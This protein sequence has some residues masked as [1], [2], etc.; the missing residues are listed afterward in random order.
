MLSLAPCVRTPARAAASATR[1]RSAVA[2]STGSAVISKRSLIREVLVFD[3]SRE[4]LLK[5]AADLPLA[6][7]ADP[8]KALYV[9]FGVATATRALL[10]PQATQP[11]PAG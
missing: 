11:R 9:R 3:S 6:V 1:A 2:S 4:G 8:R 5:H 10:D 7:I